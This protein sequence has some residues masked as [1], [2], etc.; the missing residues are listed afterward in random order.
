MVS[1]GIIDYIC[2]LDHFVLVAF[3]LAIVRGLLVLNLCN[4]FTSALIEMNRDFIL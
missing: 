4:S 1:F 2:V 3:T